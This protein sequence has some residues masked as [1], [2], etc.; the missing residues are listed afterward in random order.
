LE[1]IDDD[2]DDDDD[3]EEEAEDDDD[4]ESICSPI[5]SGLLSRYHVM[6]KG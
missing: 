1:Y 3:E 5:R 6:L 4:I 2:E